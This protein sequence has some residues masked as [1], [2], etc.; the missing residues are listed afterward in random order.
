VNW[1]MIGALGEIAGATAV[2]VSL[3]YLARQM[4]LGNRL[5]QAEAWRSR[6]GEL[7]NLNAAFGVDPRF[8]RA[9]V[10]V[11]RGALEADLE[12]DEVSLVSSYTISVAAIYEQ[13]FR[14]VRDGVLEQR[15]LDEFVGRGIFDLPFY[16]AGWAFHRQVLGR[17]FV[18]Y[19]EKLHGLA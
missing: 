5:A 12:D 1:Q 18:E 19:V 11:Y 6:F 2:V 3:V 7:T 8:H 14:E 4:A 10:K 15:A 9:M 17:P 13:L 16:R